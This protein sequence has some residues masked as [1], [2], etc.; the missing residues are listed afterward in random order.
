MEN[1]I[2]LNGN[3]NWSIEWKYGS[4]AN[5]TAGF[6]LCSN[7]GNAVGNKA[8]WHIYKGNFA[9][10]DYFDSVG[11]R[12]YTSTDIKIQDNDCLKLTNTYDPSTGKST[13]SL[14]INGKI[15]IADLQLKGSINNYHDQLDMTQYPLS[16]DFSFRYMGNTGMADWF[17]NCQLDY[18][19]ISI[20]GGHTHTY[21]ATVTVPT[22]TERGYTT[23]TCDCGDSYVD[24]YTEETGHSYTD[25]V[26]PMCGAEDPNPYAGKTIACI[27]DSITYGVGVTRD[28]TDYVKLLADALEMNY[29]RLGASGTTLCTGGHAKCNIDKLTE[30]NLSG[31]DVVTILMGIN[32]FVQ[33]RNGYYK[34]GT[35][36]STD[37]STI[38]GAVHMWCQRI[39][40]LRQTEALQNTEFYFMTPVITSWNNSVTTTRNWDQS[41]TNV[42]GYTLRDLCNAIIE[43]CALYDIP[44]IDLNLLSGLYYNSAEDNT[45]AEFG[46]DGAHPGV[47][48]HRMM[49]EAIANRLLQ[50]HLRDDHD[51]SYGSWITTTYP[52]C[53][54]GQQQRVCSLC[55][56]TESRSLDPIDHAYEK[57]ICTI[58]GNVLGDLDLDGDVDAQDLTILARHVAGIERLASANALS[59]ADVNGDGSIDASD[60]TMH[61]RYVAGIITDWDQE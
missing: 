36:D 19:K 6:L 29:I 35:I 26:C 58:C 60:L 30:A 54:G 61:A 7:K 24:D 22:C 13:L 10:A 18:L 28:E 37:T 56:A 38:Y 8:I 46:G 12:N 39:V 21:I 41:K 25:G 51:H 33:A 55:T 20:S 9:I 3:N 27:G 42:Y 4:L 11:Y 52:H 59:N 50:N 48:G 45:V 14:W 40:E 23:Y 15:A 34:L 49:A 57:G 1:I 32:D 31:A 5:G 43:V 17:M 44:V 53:H 16:G 47:T 2:E